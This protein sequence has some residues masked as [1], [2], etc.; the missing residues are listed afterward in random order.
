MLV[1]L[2]NSSL[3]HLLSQNSE[4]SLSANN[5]ESS[6]IN[7]A[8]L[9]QAEVDLATTER[10]CNFCKIKKKKKNFLS[11]DWEEIALIMLSLF[12]LLFLHAAKYRAIKSNAP[13]S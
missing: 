2:H 4:K 5:D 1:F 12:H 13:S 8:R 10:I 6:T 3:F 9:C 7:C 11:M